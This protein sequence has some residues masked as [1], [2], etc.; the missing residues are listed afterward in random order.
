MPGDQATANDLD[1]LVF[2]SLSLHR[3]TSPAMWEPQASAP[4]QKHHLNL[5]KWP[6]RMWGP[7]LGST[8]SLAW[9]W[10]E[11]NPQR[12][13]GSLLA[14]FLEDLGYLTS[15]ASDATITEGAP[16]LDHCLPLKCKNYTHAQGYISWDQGKWTHL[17]N[18]PGLTSAQPAW[19]LPQTEGLESLG[20]SWNISVKHAS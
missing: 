4:G 19:S 1:L 8:Q 11:L 2:S 18:S 9:A 20:I 16:W 15:Q 10:W 5:S 3:H 17:A 12:T 6:V 14:R 13:R 7:P